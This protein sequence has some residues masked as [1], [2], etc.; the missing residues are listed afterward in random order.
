ML[1][2]G[3]LLLK[4]EM[5]VVIYAKILN[6]CFIPTIYENSSQF[7]LVYFKRKLGHLNACLIFAIER[8]QTILRYFH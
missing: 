8:I 2:K 1:I 7:L 6:H 3:G 5:L 4:D